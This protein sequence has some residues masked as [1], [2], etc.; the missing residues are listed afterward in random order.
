MKSLQSLR[1]LFLAGLVVLLTFAALIPVG[2]VEAQHPWQSRTQRNRFRRWAGT[3]Y[4]DGYHLRQPGPSVDYYQPWSSVNSSRF[5]SWQRRESNG[6]VAPADQDVA[7]GEFIRPDSQQIKDY[8]MKQLPEPP[9]NSI[10]DPSTKMSLRD[11]FIRERNSQPSDSSLP[12]IDQQQDKSLR[13]RL[14]SGSNRHLSPIQSIRPRPS[15]SKKG[16]RKSGNQ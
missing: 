1:S 2:S 14:P 11:D 12:E 4:S 16:F 15:P 9:F 10:L 5:S 6:H 3:F 13:R 7:P 8:S